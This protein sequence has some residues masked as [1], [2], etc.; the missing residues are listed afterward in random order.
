MRL[1][2]VLLALCVGAAA[3]AQA[4]PLPPPPA[5]PPMEADSVVPFQKAPHMAAP[6]ADG[7]DE[8]SDVPLATDSLSPRAIPDDLLRRYKRDPAFQYDNPQAERP[9]V[10]RRFLEWWTRTVLEPVGESLGPGGV[11]VLLIGLAA[12]L[13]GWALTWILRIGGGSPFAKRDVVKADQPLLDVDEIA[14]V[15]LRALHRE[16]LARDDFREA[17]RYRYLLALQALDAQGAIRWNRHKTNREYVR[18]MRAAA[19]PDQSTAF[20]EATRVFDWVWYGHRPVDRDRYD[21]LAP[22]FAALDLHRQPA[23]TE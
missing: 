10:W 21:R 4:P 7:S 16:A 17:V 2:W 15:D 12:L 18:E 5:P 13:L 3:T 8:W 6:I 22:L 20:G 14:E 9:S 1:G 19:S 11:R 23:A